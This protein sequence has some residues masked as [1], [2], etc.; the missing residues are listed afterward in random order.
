MEDY[1]PEFLYHYTSINTLG[2]ILKNKNI[3]FNNITDI[4]EGIYSKKNWG[5]YCFVSSWTNIEKESIEMWKM[6]SNDLN[7][8]RIKMKAFPFK[9]YYS[10]GNGN[11]SIMQSMEHTIGLSYFI[12][13]YVQNNILHKVKYS[14][15]EY[16]DTLKREEILVYEDGKVRFD[17][18]K[19][20]KYKNEY[21][22]FQNE[23]RYILNIYPMSPL[24]MADDIKRTKA[25]MDFSKLVDLPFKDYYLY[26]SDEAF[27]D[28][29]ITLGPKTNEMDKE[30]VELL[31]EKYNLNAK[32]CTSCLRN[33]IR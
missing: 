1:I 29:E 11:E 6:Y 19:L 18:I 15:I 4:D 28:I 23:W 27:S 14:N 26:L 2:L 22:S 33:R 8:V 30:I 16:L 7:G 10:F 13:T 31:I 25:F 32:V 9:T 17:G 5:K 24:D 20:G 12:L 3:R 21:W